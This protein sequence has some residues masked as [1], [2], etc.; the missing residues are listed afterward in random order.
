MDSE[1]KST[2]K[3]ETAKNLGHTSDIRAT[4]TS[5][6]ETEVAGTDLKIDLEDEDVREKHLLTD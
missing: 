3:S 6:E 1:T 4:D 5:K 2:R